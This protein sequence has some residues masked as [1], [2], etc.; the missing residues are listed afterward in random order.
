MRINSDKGLALARAVLREHGGDW[1]NVRASGRVRDD[2]VI[3]IKRPKPST[4]NS[5]PEA[6]GLAARVRR[7]KG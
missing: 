2:G 3:V 6:T 1:E 4:Q 5:A 7:P